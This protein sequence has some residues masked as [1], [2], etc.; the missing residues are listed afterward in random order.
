MTNNRKKLEQAENYLKENQYT[1]AISLLREIHEACPEEESVLLMLAWAYYDSGDIAR[2]LDCF[3]NLFEIELRRK[4]FTGFAY[5][6]LVR[7][8]KQEKKYYDLVKICEKAVAA[9]DQDKYLL[10]EL[11]NAYLQAG[12]ATEACAVYEKMIK[13]EEDEAELYCLWGQA[14]FAAGLAA[15]SE[16]AYVR[17]G[18]IDP[19]QESHYYFKLANLF[20]RARNDNEAVRVIKKCIVI[21]PDN[22]LFHC[23]YGDCLISLGR[24]QEACD[25]YS[26]AARCGDGTRAAVYY[27]RLGNSLMNARLFA[28]AAEYFSRALNEENSEVYYN[29]LISACRAMGKED[30]AR[31]IIHELGKIKKV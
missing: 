24:V 12:R 30:E 14:L 27:N 11:G 16:D 18:Q 9:Q 29:G 10:A 28:E 20:Q 7:I 2:A 19:E 31:K 13:M 1:Q 3:H 22:P 4:V 5:D 25:A 23:F 6:E 21:D 26:R 8:Y 15:E 17:A